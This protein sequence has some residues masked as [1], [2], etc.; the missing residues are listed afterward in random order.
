[1]AGTQGGYDA[2]AL[3][4][5]LHRPAGKIPLFR[6]RSFGSSGELLVVL[7]SDLCA[8]SLLSRLMRQL[9]LE[10]VNSFSYSIMC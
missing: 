10:W 8:S 7:G 5:Q 1:M 6:G 9:L 4:K 3:S 2:V